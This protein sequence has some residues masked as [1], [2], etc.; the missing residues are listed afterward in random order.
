MPLKKYV[1]T[2]DDAELTAS[3]QR[4][5]AAQ[6]GASVVTEIASAHLPMIT[7]SAEVIAAAQDLAESHPAV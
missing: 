2:T 6:F 1:V 7:N 4:G 3:M 5:Y